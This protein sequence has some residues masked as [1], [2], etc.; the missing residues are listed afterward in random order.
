VIEKTGEI[1]DWQSAKGWDSS[2]L[3]IQERRFFIR[4]PLSKELRKDAHPR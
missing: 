4:A 1:A 2:T 3:A